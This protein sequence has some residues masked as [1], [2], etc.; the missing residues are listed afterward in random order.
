[1]MDEPVPLMWME[2]PIS[3]GQGRKAEHANPASSTATATGQ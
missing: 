2:A 3:A 1:M